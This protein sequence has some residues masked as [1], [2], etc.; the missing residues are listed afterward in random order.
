MK[1]KELK[2]SILFKIQLLKQR[3]SNQKLLL[4]KGHNKYIINFFNLSTLLIIILSLVQ[5]KWY[6]FTLIINSII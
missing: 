2:L 5:I 1:P 4:A 6:R 3:Y